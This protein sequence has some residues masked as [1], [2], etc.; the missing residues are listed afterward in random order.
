[1]A[2][3]LWVGGD[4]AGAGDWSINRNW[5]PATVPIAGDTVWIDGAV[6][7][8]AI[9]AGL[10]QSAV[11][12]A[13]LHVTKSYT[14]TIGT[15]S[16]YLQV[17]ATLCNIGFPSSGTT[18]NGSQRV[19]IN[20]G[21]VQTTCNVYG[22]SVNSTDTGLE[23]I[24]VKGTHASNVLNVFGGTV[25]LATTDKAEVA[26]VATIRVQGPGT[27][28]IGPVCTLTTLH[29]G[30]GTVV[31]QGSNL[32]T[33]NQAGGT[34]TVY[35]SATLVTLNQIAGTFRWLSSGTISTAFISGTLTSSDDSRAKTCS[36]LNVYRGAVVE[37][38]TGAPLSVT[39]TSGI[40]LQQ[41]GIEDVTLS[42][43]KH[44]TLSTSAI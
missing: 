28:R 34:Y 27:L 9:N 39:I 4:S 12:L 42:L 38:D 10:N 35:G 8:Q 26:T 18:E 16:A 13:A 29:V 23:P 43:G 14:G 36:I 24:R 22:S 19:K 44:L 7:V 33:I 37:L 20:F 25:G 17:G 32:T 5:S 41:C 2:T 21:S 40:D 3:Y 15:S 1:M 6:S 30:G 31:N 11:T